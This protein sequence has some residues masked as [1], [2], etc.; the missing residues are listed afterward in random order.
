MDPT[1]S[2]VLLKVLV[3]KFRA[4][5]MRRLELRARCNV[6]NQ[7]E[8]LLKPGGIFT[9]TIPNVEPSRGTSLVAVCWGRAS[10]PGAVAR[11]ETAPGVFSHEPFH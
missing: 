1:L 3:D 8:D 2:C 5:P 4:R 9:H 10:H 7:L 6:V 11:E